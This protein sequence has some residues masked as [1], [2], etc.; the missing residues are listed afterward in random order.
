[1]DKIEYIAKQ[2]SKATCKKYEH[3][4]ITRIWNLLNDL[5]IKIITQQHVIRPKGRALT[6]LFFPQLQIHIEVFEKFHAKDENIIFDNIREADIIN[7][8]GHKVLRVHITKKFVLNSIETIN[9]EI[10]DIVKEI[11]EKQKSID[12]FK[13]WDME[14]EQNP[15]TYI[16]KGFIDLKDDC[17][18]RTMVDAANCFGNNY[19]PKGIWKGSAKH[20]RENDKIIWFPKLYDNGKWNNVEN[21][22]EIK[23]ICKIPKIAKKHIDK[24]INNGVH[25]RIV[26]A[27]VKSPL[28][29]IMYRF[30]GEYKL[31]LKQSNYKSGL[32]WEKT[33]DRVKT[34][35]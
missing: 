23:E 24:I 2:F 3:Y 27:R 31:N 19:K 25:K 33:F 32:I 30:K 9:K 26:F 18:F 7:A 35:D 22:N 16:A 29:D 20:G 11:K 13:P 10:D 14:A 21:L 6:D 34:Y 12:K 1:M 5:S 17:A 15:K 28:G 8:T 4:V